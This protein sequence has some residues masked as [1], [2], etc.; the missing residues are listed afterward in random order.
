MNMEVE[1]SDIRYAELHADSL[2]EQMK[3][4]CLLNPHLH[5]CGITHH[6]SQTGCECG[7]KIIYST[8]H[9]GGCMC[10]ESYCDK[11]GKKYSNKITWDE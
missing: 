6:I 2:Q 4:D 7:G 9:A 1:T 3:F 11:C 5:F 10:D 8:T